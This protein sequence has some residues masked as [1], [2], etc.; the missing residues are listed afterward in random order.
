MALK[1]FYPFILAFLGGI[2]LALVMPALLDFSLS[3]SVS[4]FDLYVSL[5]NTQLATKQWPVKPSHPC[6][7][8]VPMFR[9]VACAAD[10]RES[11]INL[12]Y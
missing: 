1:L 10:G 11:Y 8:H 4:P 12:P 9:T 6:V 5:S 3:P 2:F 7:F